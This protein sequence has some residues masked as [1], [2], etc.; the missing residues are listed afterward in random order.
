MTSER[1]EKLI[2]GLLRRAII[3]KGYRPRTEDEEDAMLEAFG[4]VEISEA[5][6]DRMLR[7]IRGEQQ[8]D[9]ELP[10]EFSGG[11]AAEVN[12]ELAAMFRGEGE[13]I[14]PELQ[15]R[16]DELERRAAESGEAEDDDET[17]D[18]Q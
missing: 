14:S 2:D 17:E 13:E 10:G 11:T 15:A 4:H 3:A 18:G 1:Q 5:K 7:K 16:L 8:F 6:R 12:E 9:A